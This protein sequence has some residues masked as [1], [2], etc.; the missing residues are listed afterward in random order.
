MKSCGKRWG[1]VQHCWVALTQGGYVPCR[2]N[3]LHAIFAE[4]GGYPSTS[5]EKPVRTRSLGPK[6][7]GNP[8]YKTSTTNSIHSHQLILVFSVVMFEPNMDPQQNDDIQE[9]TKAP[10]K[11]HTL[12]VLCRI[13]R[14]M[15]A[16]TSR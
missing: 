2:D 12:G 16:C 13:D 10:S 15:I 1:S 14:L 9:Q 11:H 8:S 6:K 7:S 4:P 3:P 5:H